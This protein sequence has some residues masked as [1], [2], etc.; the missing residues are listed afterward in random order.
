MKKVSLQEIKNSIQG[1]WVG[2]FE[3][4]VSSVAEIKEAQRTDLV[5]ASNEKYLASVKQSSCGF[6]IVPKGDW[7]LAC[8]YIKVENPYFAFA[9]VL[10]LFQTKEASVIGV[11]P[12]ANIDPSV[13]LGE[14]VVIY[15]GVFLD[16]DV[17]IG[18]N[19]VIMANVSVGKSTKI[20]TDCIIYSNVSIR[21]EVE[22]RNRVIVQCNAVIGSDGYGFVY[23]QGEHYKIPQIGN[24][25]L[26]DDVEIGAN[27]CVDRASFGTTRVGAGT[28]IDNLVQIAHNVE[29]GKAC[30]MAS[31]SGLAGST[32][33]G[34][35][36]TFGG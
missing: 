3:G 5:Y 30:L 34:D 14:N 9:K 21:E 32:K 35:F 2:T 20:G 19:S 33:V 26:E 31:Q 15:P 11:S 28:K 29:M 12:Q 6:A 8:P 23:H 36:V 18:D 4:F 24:V 27:S 10:E 16:Q 7:D 17:I 1:E 13:K 25:I 22:I